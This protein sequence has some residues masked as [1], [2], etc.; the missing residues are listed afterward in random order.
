VIDSD[1]AL[2]ARFTLESERGGAVEA[3][4]FQLLALGDWSGGA[5]KKPLADRRP[6]AIDTD[7]FL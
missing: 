2:E 1:D 4:P 5:D 3:P 7:N 6:I